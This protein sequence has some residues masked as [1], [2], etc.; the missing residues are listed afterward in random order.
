MKER[1]RPDYAGMNLDIFNGHDPGGVLWQPRIDFWYE[2]NRKRGTLPQHLKGLS[3]FEVY[4][5][6]FGSVRYFVEPLR[7]RY[8]NVNIRDEWIGKR[9]RRRF[10]ETPVGILT[11]L[12]LYDEWG[13]SC[14]N[15]EYRLKSPDDFRIYEAILE[16]EE[17]YWDQSGYEHDLE[18]VDGRGLPQFYFRRSPIQRLFIEDMGF[19]NSIFMMHDHPR[20]IDR[21]VAVA[22]A[23]EDAMYD[24]LCSAP[25]EILNFGENID[26]HMDSPGIWGEYLEAHYGKRVEQLRNA[27][28]KTH[29]H[30][31]GAM[32]LLIRE[33]SESP[34]DGIEAATPLPQGDVT[35]E[36]IA[37][38]LGDKVCLDGIPAIF[39]LPLYP[40]ETLITCAETIVELFHPRLVLGISDEIP[41]DGDIERVR[42]I[43]KMVQ[44]MCP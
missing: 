24:V 15:E 42:M 32:K 44:E 5:Y 18:G 8:N 28:K 31:D 2:V 29:I 27:G 21:Y 7:V 20:V 16:A 25:V 35:L 1:I 9:S 23:A 11:E 3:L 13:V 39:F 12:F 36:E 26:H 19:E 43:G 22:T 6:C 17:W 34:F 10:W 4:D 30:I 37:E 38:A 33:I 40:V 14:Y 41:P